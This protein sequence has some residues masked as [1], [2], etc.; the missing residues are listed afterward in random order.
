MA[1]HVYTYGGCPVPRLSYAVLGGEIY[2]QCTV[3]S[4]LSLHVIH[5]RR[6]GWTARQEQCAKI[7]ELIVAETISA[8][9]PA[10]DIYMHVFST[11]CFISDMKP[12][13]KWI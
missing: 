8:F 7:W 1:V 2:L 6:V 13:S 9:V 5:C 4:W 11:P 3:L 12:I 10:G